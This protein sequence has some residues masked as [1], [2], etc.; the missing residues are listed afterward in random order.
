VD[1][2]DAWDIALYMAAGYVAV[3]ALVRL[4]LHERDRLVQRFRTEML[5]ERQRQ[6]AAERQR[7]KDE[8]KAR[9]RGA[10]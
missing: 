5:A 1:G 3:I 6:A 7:K 9:D 2:L 10:A 4:M 8:A